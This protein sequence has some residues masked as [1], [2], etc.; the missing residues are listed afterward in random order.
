METNQNQA[1][2]MHPLF[3]DPM[4]REVRVEDRDGKMSFKYVDVPWGARLL[5]NGDIEFNMF[6]PEAEKIEVSGFGGTIGLEKRPL[7]KDEKGWFHGSFSGI[8]NG[9]HYHRY[10]VDG[11]EAAN[12]IAPVAYGCFGAT[13][14]IEK[15]AKGQDFWFI[16]EVPHGDVQIRTYTSH[17][18]GHLKQCYVYLPPSYE[19]NSTRKYPVMYLQHG[20]GEDETGWIWNGKAN[21]IM[22]NLIA[23]GKAEEM[24]LVMSCG[25]AFK[26]AE[27]PVFYPGDFNGEMIGDVIPFIESEYRVIRNRE[28]RA[29]A[30]LSLGSAQAI[31]I[32]SLNQ[33][34]FAHLGVFSGVKYEETEEIL[35]NFEQN[36]IRNIWM[37]GGIDEHLDVVQKPFVERF[38]Q[39]GAKGGQQNYEGHHEW[40]VWRESL[41]DFASL[42]FKDAGI[43]PDSICEESVTEYK[44]T[45][46]SEEQLKTQTFD[47]HMLM[48]DPIYKDLIF[49][50]D[51][52]GNPAGKYK[53]KYHGYEILDEEKGKVVFRYFAP[54][55]KTVVLNLWGMEKHSLTKQEDGWWS[56]LVENLEQGFHYYDYILNGAEVLDRNAPCGYGG[57]KAVNYV[58]I[59]ETKFTLDHIR[60]VPH[61][62]V[63]QNYYRS[64]RSGR[65]K[66]CY[67]Y[68]P[69]AYEKNENRRY[70]V[71]YLQHGGGENEMGWLWQGRINAIADNLI[72]EGKMEEMIIVMTSNYGFPKAYEYDPGLTD[73]VNEIPVSL[74]PFIDQRYRTI[75]DKDSRAMSGLSMGSMIS[76]RM[77]FDY[78]D[79]F[80]NVG[81]FSGG[82]IIRDANQGLDYSSILL[83]KEEFDKRFK[84]FFVACG[85]EEWMCPATLEAEKE[86][87]NAG[88]T[89]Y[90]FHDHG[91]HD[92]TFWRHCA[93]QF[94]PLL[95]K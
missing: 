71:V 45:R 42:L 41:R 69:P 17:I 61:G 84:I 63:H 8:G 52:K 26:K 43:T 5:E 89:I 85:N 4:Y 46:V 54:E 33:D 9:F 40:H 65:E 35:K 82:L 78:P 36:P 67:V 66:I 77:V 74:I 72:A 7:T 90:S 81:L 27:D 49:A 83:N 39:L 87:K 13:N 38:L 94:L 37:T 10:F 73:G 53:D 1:M 25:Y 88:V 58:D 6:A 91:Y 80:S 75:A 15:P 47:S 93:S 64:D 3:F 14:F 79:L 59:P 51:E 76:Q 60:E 19:K 24:I 21:F 28:F 12:P 55:A 2:T 30:G 22:D 48:F 92:W 16:K 95:F 31:Q 29:M 68:T 32:V 57:F 70:P 23:E 34:R 56:V 86:I 11:V 50:F 62:V 18:N 44:A 20:V